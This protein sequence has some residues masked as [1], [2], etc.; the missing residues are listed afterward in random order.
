M[1]E[2]D[3]VA[4]PPRSPVAYSL[5]DDQGLVRFVDAAGSTRFKP[6]AR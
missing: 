3:L 4:R 6:G 5:A 1:F 2:H